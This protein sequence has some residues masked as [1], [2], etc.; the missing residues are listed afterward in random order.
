M[1]KR[2]NEEKAA[3]DWQQRYFKQSSENDALKQRYR[4]HLELLQ[5]L[6]SRLILQIDDSDPTF[7]QEIQSLRGRLKGSET[8]LSALGDS[9]KRIDRLLLSQQENFSENDSENEGMRSDLSTHEKAPVW[10]R[11]QRRIKGLMNQSEQPS[12]DEQSVEMDDDEDHDLEELP[13]LD[14]MQRALEATPGYGAISSKVAGHLY[15]L[16]DQLSF[17]ESAEAD[18]E[19]FRRRVESKVNWYELPPTLE[20]LSNLVIASVGAQQRQLDYFLEGLNQQLLV[21]QEAIE[22]YSGNE[23]S[24]EDVS[25]KLQES[26]SVHSEQVLAQFSEESDQAIQISIRQHLEQISQAAL[27]AIQQGQSLSN[28]FM[29]KLEGMR[30]QVRSMDAEQSK[31]RQQLKQE[32]GKVLKDVLTGLSNREA[33]NERLELEFERWKRY[34]HPCSLVVSKLDSFNQI[35]ERYGSLSGDRT[36]QIVAKELKQRIRTTDFLARYGGEEFVFILPETDSDIAYE[37]MEKLRK[38]VSSLPF[39]FKDQRLQVTMSFGI[40]GFAECDNARVLLGRAEQSLT[41]AR[42]AGRN[43][44][45]IWRMSGP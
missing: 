17:P 37:V 36:I 22:S 12:L 21:V 13:P 39:H 18:V 7:N 24:W 20:D 33:L 26:I 11:I 1:S 23:Q 25:V 42:E 43:C 29:P 31:L 10:K 38:T 30:Q 8:D 3:P 4:E 40:V 44:V 14:E 5:R 45:R 27:K 35:T 41:H 19:A 2:A 9:L 16:L 6:V 32:R 34:Q 28:D 15:N